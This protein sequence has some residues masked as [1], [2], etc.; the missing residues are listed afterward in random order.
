MLKMY[1]PS[2]STEVKSTLSGTQDKQED[3]NDA[4]VTH[5]LIPQRKQNDTRKASEV[6][7]Y[8]VSWHNTCGY[9]LL[10]CF[11]VRNRL[12]VCGSSTFKFC[13]LR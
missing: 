11:A 5:V 9:C 4:R 8:K 10:C 7:N 3:T 2:V 1:L 12:G 6:G 13:K